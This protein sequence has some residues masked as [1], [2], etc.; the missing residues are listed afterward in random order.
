MNDTEET[1]KDEKEED[2]KPTYVIYRTRDTL[3]MENVPV[4]TAHILKKTNDAAIHIRYVDEE[5]IKDLSREL[6]V[7]IR[8]GEVNGNKSY[9]LKLGEQLLPITF[10]IAKSGDHT[11]PI[12][13]K[14][15][16]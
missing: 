10:W 12:L 5:F 16:T 14:K 3:R 4:V 9:T 13:Q 15:Y 11:E 8:P 2:K 7:D 1:E 6:N